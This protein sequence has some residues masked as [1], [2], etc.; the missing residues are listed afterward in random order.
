M[1]EEKKVKNFFLKQKGHLQ[2]DI[3][4]EKYL[5]FFSMIQVVDKLYV[6]K[7]NDDDSEK[8]EGKGRAKTCRKFAVYYNFLIN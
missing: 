3:P 7:I 5:N 4:L 8:C 1:E 2:K 6:L